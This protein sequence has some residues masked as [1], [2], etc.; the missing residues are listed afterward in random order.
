MR[1]EIDRCRE[2]Y[3]DA[4]TGIAMLPGALG[5]VRRRRPRPLR[6]HP[7]PHRGPGLRRVRP[8]GPGADAG[9]A[10]RR[11][12]TLA[13]LMAPLDRRVGRRPPTA[14]GMIAFP[15]AARG[16]DAR[17]SISNVVVG[18]LADD[19]RRV[20]VRPV[21]RGPRRRSAA[22]LVGDRRRRRSSASAR[23]RGGRSAATA[24]PGGCGRRWPACRSIV[25]AAWW[26]MAVPAR[27]VAHAVLGRRSSRPVAIALGAAALTAWD[28]FLDPQMTAEGYWRWAR[29]GS[30][31]GHPA[32]ELRRVAA[33]P[34]PP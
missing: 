28:L 23:R 30:L 1:F 13:P 21:G 27:E 33:S 34:A 9:E 31:P 19:D 2:L 29:R 14:A 4:E 12:A 20:G 15:L 18:G 6:P 22:A 10:R 11:G 17:R 25:P 24:T 5:A 16:S 7:R 8:A 32:V 3:R 26:A